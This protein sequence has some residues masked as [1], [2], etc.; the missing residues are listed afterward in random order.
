MARGVNLVDYRL[1]YESSRPKAK[2]ISPH[3]R[4]QCGFTIVELLVAA[5]ITATIA[6]AG[7]RFYA[8]VHGAALSQTNVSDLQQLCRKSMQDIRRSFRMAGFRLAGHPP[9]EIKAD[10]LAIYYGNS[11][12]VDTVRYYLDEYTS[13]QYSAMPDLPG[14]TRIYYLMKQTNS[15]IIW[16][17]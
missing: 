17:R 12:P 2:R 7:F 13:S 16:P 6:T 8:S 14:G 11:Q 1:V 9:W 5:L 15:K 3:S 10:T 4:N